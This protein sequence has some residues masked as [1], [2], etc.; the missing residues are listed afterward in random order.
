MVSACIPG[1]TT[2]EVA[3]IAHLCHPQPSANDN[4]SGSGTLIETA[5]VLN[6]LI[7]SGELAK[8]QRTIRFLWVP[9]MTGTYAYLSANENRIGE[10]VAAINLG[11]GRRKPGTVQRSLDRRKTPLEPL[12]GLWRIPCRVYFKVYGKRSLLI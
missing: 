3:A 8:P 9:E 10:T 1:V 4:A 5:R 6:T 2:E 12:L 7:Q 11:H